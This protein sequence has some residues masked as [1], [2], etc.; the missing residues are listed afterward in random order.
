MPAGDQ[1]LPTVLS[2][3]EKRGLL[4][5][6]DPALPNITAMVIGE[7]VKGPSLGH[8]LA[9]AAL[10]VISQIEKHKDVIWTTLVNGKVTFI[11]RKLWAP[12][13]GVALARQAWQSDGLSKSA[14]ALLKS[15]D[16]GANDRSGDKQSVGELESRLLIRV[17]NIKNERAQQEQRIEN[18]RSF[19]LKSGL[20]GPFPA[21]EE[22]KA[23]LEKTI[24]GFTARFPWQ[25]SQ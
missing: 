18:W 12:F 23:L 22:A 3:L 6:S 17:Y 8:P 7:P 1:Y 9:R 11:H 20:E 14:R 10:D 15:V 13:L 2:E 19:L 21:P 16:E 24:E 25:P 5:A 4:L